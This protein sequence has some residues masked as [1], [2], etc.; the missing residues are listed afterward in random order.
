MLIQAN[1]NDTVNPIAIPNISSYPGTN[2]AIESAKNINVNTPAKI[3]EPTI[4]GV[5][6]L[7]FLEIFT[8]SGNKA[9]D[10]AIAKAI[11]RKDNDSLIFNI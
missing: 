3:Q 2:A 9:I 4:R 6:L 10:V 1:G 5:F 7:N 11:T 8:I